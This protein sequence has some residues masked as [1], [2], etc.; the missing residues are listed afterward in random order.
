MRDV[1]AQDYKSDYEFKQAQKAQ[2][3]ASKGGRTARTNGRGKAF[4]FT[5]AS[6]V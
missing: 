5:P 4:T 1:K 6:D 2:R 3:K